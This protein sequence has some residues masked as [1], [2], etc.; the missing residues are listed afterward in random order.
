MAEPEAQFRRC[1]FP[2]I[3]GKSHFDFLYL[4]FSDACRLRQRFV[5]DEV[6]SLW[7]RLPAAIRSRFGHGGTPTGKSLT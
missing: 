4:I 1:I 3:A 6:Q 5:S 7:E 2:L